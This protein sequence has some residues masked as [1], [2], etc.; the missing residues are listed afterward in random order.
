MINLNVN[1]EFKD[2]LELQKEF[3]MKIQ[4][5]ILKMILKMKKYLQMKDKIYIQVLSIK[6]QLKVLEWQFMM[7]KNKFFKLILLIMKIYKFYLML[8]SKFILNSSE[9]LKT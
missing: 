6:L 7:M 4:I 3:K 9:D 2:V 1:Q 5:N 8:E